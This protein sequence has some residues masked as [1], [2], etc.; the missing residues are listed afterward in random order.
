MI[1]VTRQQNLMT[2]DESIGFVTKS[3]C[4]Q[5]TDLSALGPMPVPEK[6]TTTGSFIFI[7]KSESA[8]QTAI[9][10]VL[11]MTLLYH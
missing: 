8:P 2:S 10:L 3:Q 1:F 6:Q 5:Q 7:T 4:S 9:S 11:G